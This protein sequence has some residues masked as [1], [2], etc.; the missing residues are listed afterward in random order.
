[1]TD[2]PASD[3]TKVCIRCR[4]Q[5]KPHCARKGCSWTR[6]TDCKITVTRRGRV[7]HD[8]GTIIAPGT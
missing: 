3:V 1:M 2:E 8:K 4:A 7:I 5:L 6:C